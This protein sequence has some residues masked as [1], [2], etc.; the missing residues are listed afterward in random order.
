MKENILIPLIPFVIGILLKVLLDFNLALFIVKNFYWL[1]VRTIFRTKPV[2]ISGE[3]SQMWENEASEKYSGEN[4]RKSNLS[5]KQ[6]GKYIYGEFRANNDEQYYVFGEVIG[7]NIIGKWADKTNDLGYFGSFE[8]RI[9]DSMKI[10]GIWLGHSNSKPDQINSN[11]WK[12][13]K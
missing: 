1:P 4:G 13:K 6:F 2:D 10:E 12:W 9:I 7:K 5:I 3:W 8:L 11:N